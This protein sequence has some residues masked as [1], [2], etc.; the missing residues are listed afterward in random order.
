MAKQRKKNI[1]LLVVLGSAVVLVLIGSTMAY[2]TS[3]DAVTNKF[4]SSSFDITLTETKWNAEKAKNVIPGDEL[5]KNP[6]VI[7]NEETD[8]YIFLRVTVPCDTQMIDNDDGTQLGAISTNVPLY[9][10]MISNE[11]NPEK[12]IYNENFSAEQTAHNHWKLVNDT[13]KDY[14]KYIETTQQYVYVY[15]YASGNEL[16]PLKKGEV[17][18]P[19]FDKLH[20]W[21]FSE[22]GFDINQS[23]SVRVEALGIQASLSGYTANQI[24]EIWA[25]LEGGGG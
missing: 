13:G 22:K 10:F 12:Y 24:S 8:G 20:L 6:Q 19:L 16:T 5:D 23:H 14:T 15:A 21:N 1:R 9:K 11:N 2:F 4:I 25:I 3:T 7:N 18:E 17:T